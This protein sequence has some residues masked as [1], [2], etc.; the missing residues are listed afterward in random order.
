MYHL[1]HV[2]E[3]VALA[4]TQDPLSVRETQLK[5]DLFSHCSGPYSLEQVT[6]RDTVLSFPLYD[7]EIVKTEIF[8]TSFNNRLLNAVNN[9]FLCFVFSFSFLF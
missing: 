2:L 9:L 8:N 4:I 5:L 6:S 3:S 1:Q 7:Q